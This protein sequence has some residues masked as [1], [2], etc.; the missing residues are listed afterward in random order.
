[1]K[2][3]PLLSFF[4]VFFYQRCK[5]KTVASGCINDIKLIFLI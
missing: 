1:M 5:F 3:H 2:I 4:F